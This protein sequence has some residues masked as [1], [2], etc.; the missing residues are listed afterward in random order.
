MNASYVLDAF[1]VMAFLRDEPG[2]PIVRELLQAAAREEIQ[3]YLCLVNY[4]EVLYTVERRW[5][6]TELYKVIAHLDDLPIQVMP[7]DRPL[8]L[9]A[10]HVKAHHRLSYADALAVALAKEFN[11]AV[12][13][14]DPEFK[15]VEG[16]V[17]IEWLTQPNA[18]QTTL[19]A[20]P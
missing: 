12:V 2:G 5:G 1:A 16:L 19:S 4:G 20:A 7:I 18:R 11:A 3:L 10:A 15:S 13:T 9:A 8:T 14:G 17:S 6:E